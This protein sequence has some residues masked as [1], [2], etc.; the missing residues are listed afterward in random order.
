MWTV[1]TNVQLRTN[2]TQFSNYSFGN[3]NVFY[4]KLAEQLIYFDNWKHMLL[5]NSWSCS[6]QELCRLTHLFPMHPFSTPWKHQKT[7]TFG[8]FGKNWWKISQPEFFLTHFRIMSTFYPL[9]HSVFDNKKPEVF[10]CLGV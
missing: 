5:M 4:R 6:W 8:K 3:G 1:K 7:V 10:W 2:H 9:S